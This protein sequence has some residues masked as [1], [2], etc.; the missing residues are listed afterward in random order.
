LSMAADLSS[1][2]LWCLAGFVA[3]KNVDQ[4]CDECD[5]SA[6]QH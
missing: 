1:S 6:R 2:A 4:V 5:K 3:T